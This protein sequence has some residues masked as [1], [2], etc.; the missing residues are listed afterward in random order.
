MRAANF[1]EE[2]TTSIAG[3]SGDGAVTLT[4]ISS[5]P[6]FSTV[7]GTGACQVRYTIEKVSTKAFEVGIGSVASNALTRTRPQVTWDGSTY[8]DSTPS[9]LQFGASPTSGDVLIR[10]APLAESFAP[11]LP[12]MNKSISGDAN[13]RDYP[14][15][16]SYDWSNAGGNSDVTA[17]RESYAYYRLDVAGLLTGMQ[18]EVTTGGGNLKTALH[19]V[20]YDGLPGVKIVDFGAVDT[21]ATGIKTNTS[22]GSWTPTGSLWLTPGWYA[23]GFIGDD[24]TLDVRGVSLSNAHHHCSPLGRAGAYGWGHTIYVAG[25][26]ASGLPSTPDLTGGTIIGSGLTSFPW[27]GLKVVA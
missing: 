27:F 9:P 2:T 18:F 23:I 20:G 16:A 7:F 3:T 24:S 4:A 10:M 15:S 5:V 25:S 11:A 26:Y 12:G 13:W 19:S 1:V 17:N 8:D 21:S 22:T 14:L 6:R